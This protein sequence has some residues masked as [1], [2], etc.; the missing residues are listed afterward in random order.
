MTTEPRTVEPSRIRTALAVLSIGLGLI[1]VAAYLVITV[2]DRVS[3]GA[4]FFIVPVVGFF[5]PMLPSSLQLPQGH[6]T[7][8]VLFSLAAA[9]IAIV[10]LTLCGLNDVTLWYCW[11][12]G[13]LLSVAAG[14]LA[15]MSA[16]AARFR[17]V[18]VVD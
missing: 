7:K 4:L 8:A 9:V 10:T 5:I 13:A 15:A 18:D 3:S 16:G 6:R 12:G 2:T 11:V 17:A 1:V 14:M